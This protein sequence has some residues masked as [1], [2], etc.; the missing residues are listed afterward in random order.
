MRKNKPFRSLLIALAAVLMMMTVSAQTPVFADEPAS[1]AT[2]QCTEM[3]DP[4][5]A[6]SDA[7][8]AETQKSNPLLNGILVLVV[9][10]A[11]FICVREIHRDNHRK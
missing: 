6:A 10:G 11:V 3:T 9:V 1:E 2:T 8:P 7:A 4:S 5:E